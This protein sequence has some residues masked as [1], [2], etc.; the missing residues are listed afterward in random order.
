VLQSAF[1]SCAPRFSTPHRRQ[2]RV[3][4]NGRMPESVSRSRWYRSSGTV[5][6]S[7]TTCE[8]CSAVATTCPLHRSLTISCAPSRDGSR[9][10]SRDPVEHSEDTGGHM[11]TLSLEQAARL[12]G[13]GK[14]ILARAISGRL[15]AGSFAGSKEGG[16]S[17]VDGTESARVYPFPAP[18][19]TTAELRT[20]LTLAEE[21]LSELKVMLEDMRRDRDAW[22]EQTQTRLLPAP[23]ARMS[24]WPWRRTAA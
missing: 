10:A 9:G 20:R 7:G 19:E 13:R 2:K 8:Q 12:T 4:H 6:S 5:L 15:F 1:S 14:T 23:A 24:W 18:V 17:N 22:R 3:L 16:G 11:T 21:R